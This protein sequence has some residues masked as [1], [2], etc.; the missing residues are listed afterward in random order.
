M[1]KK[2]RAWASALL[3]V[4]LVVLLAW[5]LVG[6]AVS[7]SVLVA[8]FFG[9]ENQDW[10]MPVLAIPGAA[11]LS[12]LGLWVARD[13]WRARRPRRRER[14]AVRPGDD[15]DMSEVAGVIQRPPWMG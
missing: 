8:T 10:V 6:A 14:K 9:K 12:V 5:F 3:F 13:V 4:N 1:L 15:G 2:I 7:V 11:A